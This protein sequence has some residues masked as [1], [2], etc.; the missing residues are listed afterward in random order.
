MTGMKFLDTPTLQT[1]NICALHCTIVHRSRFPNNAA[2]CSLSF[3]VESNY[4]AVIFGE[5]CHVSPL[6]TSLTPIGSVTV[7]VTVSLLVSHVPSPPPPLV[8]VV[9]VAVQLRLGGGTKNANIV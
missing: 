4:C 6:C 5:T 9:V 7:S 8:M 1:M 2:F 3:T